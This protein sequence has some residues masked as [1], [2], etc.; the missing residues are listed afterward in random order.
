VKKEQ[1]IPTAMELAQTLAKKNPRAIAQA[2][3]NINGF[4]VE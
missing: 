3:A 4:Y 1:L 2:K